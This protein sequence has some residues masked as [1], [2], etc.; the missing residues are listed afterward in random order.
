MILNNTKYRGGA[1]QIFGPNILFFDIFKNYNKGFTLSLFLFWRNLIFSAV[2]L[3][4]RTHSE[5]N[6]KLYLSVENLLS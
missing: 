1:F 6:D 5:G 4:A 3:F 2:L